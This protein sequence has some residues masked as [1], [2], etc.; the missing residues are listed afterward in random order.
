MTSFDAWRHSHVFDAG[1]PLAERAT[2]W[3]MALTALMMLA[4]IA[5]GWAF[6]SMALLADGWHMSSHVLALGLAAASYAAA[7]RLAGN[8][9]FA[10]GTWKIEVLG[11]YSSAILLLLVAALMLWQSV[12]RLLAPEPIQYDAAIAIGLAAALSLRNIRLPTQ[13]Q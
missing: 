2:L 4:E 7:R 9:R 5:G 8:G 6:N 1:N 3:A 11:G 10:F 13:G 12:A